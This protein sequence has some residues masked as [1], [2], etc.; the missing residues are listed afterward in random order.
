MI[1]E[2]TVMQQRTQQLEEALKKAV[3]QASV[4]AQQLANSPNKNG[5]EQETE[6]LKKELDTALK[7]IDSTK[8]TLESLQKEKKIDTVKGN[9][10]EEQRP[11]EPQKPN[12]S[13]RQNEYGQEQAQEPN[14]NTL[15]ENEPSSQKNIIDDIKEKAATAKVLNEAIDTMKKN[16]GNDKTV[17]QH[18]NNNAQDQSMARERQKQ[19]QPTKKIK[20]KNVDDVSNALDAAIEQQR[21]T[22]IGEALKNTQEKISKQ[23]IEQAK[24]LFSGIRKNTQQGD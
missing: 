22:L 23:V 24:E 5:N 11:T 6:K 12:S 16:T 7:T 17:D 4:I 14:D 8:K 15:P 9:S 13:N 21:E 19:N 10:F 20:I 1:N 3:N 18:N 2:K